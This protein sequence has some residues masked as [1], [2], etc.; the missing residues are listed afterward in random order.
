[1][2]L[3]WTCSAETNNQVPD[4]KLN[5]RC[6]TMRHDECEKYRP[7]DRMNTIRK[8]AQLQAAATTMDLNRNCCE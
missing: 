8:A 5:E 6:P 1:M 2:Q 7:V 4:L 3:G